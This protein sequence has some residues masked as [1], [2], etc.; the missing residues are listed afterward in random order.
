MADLLDPANVE[1]AL[2]QFIAGEVDYDIHKNFECGEED[3]EDSYPDLADAF[4][5]YLEADAA[6][7]A[8]DRADADSDVFALIAEIAS[9]LTDATDEGEY[10]AASLIGDLANGRKTIT[11][12]REDLADITFRHV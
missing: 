2:R 3:G 1:R 4:L 5:G 12:A 10:H 11:E 6:E 7:T 8:T 9:R